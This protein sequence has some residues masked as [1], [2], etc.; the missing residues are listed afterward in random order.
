MTTLFYGNGSDDLMWG[1]TGNDL[2]IGGM[3]NDTLWGSEGND[4]LVGGYG[5]DVLIGGW[6]YNVMYGGEGADTFVVNY[7]DAW[8][9]NVIEDYQAGDRIALGTTL[10]NAYCDGYDLVLG[11]GQGENSGG[12]RIKNVAYTPITINGIT[13]NQQ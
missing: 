11:V 6:G 7:D 10:N 13:Y 8:F 12:V 3:G 1:N 2:L 9:F 4:I 5:D